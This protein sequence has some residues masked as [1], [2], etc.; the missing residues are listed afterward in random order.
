MLI[1]CS[2]PNK[3]LETQWLQTTQIYS[4]TF[5]RSESGVSLGGLKQGV[6]RAVFPLEIPGRVCS[7]CPPHHPTSFPS[8]LPPGLAP[9]EGF[10]GGPVVRNPPARQRCRRRGFDPWVQKIPWRRKWQPTPVFLPGKSQGR[11]SLAGYSA[12]GHR[13]SDTT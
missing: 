4:P 12:W 13:Q 3:L 5:W 6:I 10:P 11:R 1:S 7:H 2:C 9:R 8:Y